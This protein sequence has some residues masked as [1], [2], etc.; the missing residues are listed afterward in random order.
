MY[1]RLENDVLFIPFPHY[2]P[3]GRV[4]QVVYSNAQRLRN[5]NAKCATQNASRRRRFFQPFKTTTTFT[6]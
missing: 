6:I 5:K 1:V 4:S 3:F 2:L